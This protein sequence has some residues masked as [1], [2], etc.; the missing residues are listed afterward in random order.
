MRDSKKDNDGTAKIS[1]LSS[2]DDWK[3]HGWRFIL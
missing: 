2:I 3:R 1:F